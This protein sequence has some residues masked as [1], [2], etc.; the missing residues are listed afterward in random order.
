MAAEDSGM[1]YTTQ[2][3]DFATIVFRQRAL[4]F[5]AVRL[6]FRFSDLNID[7]VLFN[8]KCK[9]TSRA[10]LETN[11]Q[12]GDIR[13]GASFP[14]GPNPPDPTP[15]ASGR[16]NAYL[17]NDSTL[18]RFLWVIQYFVGAGYYVILDWHPT[19][20]QPADIAVA[21]D[22]VKFRQ[23]WVSLFQAIT[24]TPGWK[25]G[26]LQ[27]RLM[28][29]LMNEPDVYGMKWEAP[30]TFKE[31]KLPP[32]S[33]LYLPTMR[34]LVALDPSVLII[35]EGTGQHMIPGT[36]WG[37]G[38]Q[39][40]SLPPDASNPTQFFN[41]LM[42]ERAIAAR[43]IIGPH[44]YPPSISGWTSA[45]SGAPLW[46]MLRATVGTG[47]LFGKT[48][49]LVVGETGSRL[50]LPQDVTWMRDFAMWMNNMGA[51][52]ESG[53]IPLR[54]WLWWAWSPT[55]ADT[56]G[57]VKNN[58]IDIEWSKVDTLSTYGNASPATVQNNGGG[59]GLL[60]WYLW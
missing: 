9:V 34:A 42:A 7:P 32:V 30:T 52:A 25:N 45:I 28:L 35:I 14:A 27:G 4:G 3:S 23:N 17:P 2:A 40:E 29:D 11:L 58:Y 6:P 37:N 48:F 8:F 1:E 20:A 18:N 38:F 24:N 47:S 59:L 10:D 19:A 50:T 41:A 13:A 53:R 26:I 16:C 22:P 44:L 46:A 39:T 54:T 43:T 5:N 51:A 49:P 33:D 15:E 12:N 60:P 21:S 36:S 57:I 31:I 56:G 55:A